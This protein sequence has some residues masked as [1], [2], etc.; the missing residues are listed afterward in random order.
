MQTAWSLPA[1][2][3][4]MAIVLSLSSLLFIFVLILLAKCYINIRNLICII[5]IHKKGHLPLLSNDYFE[6][7]AFVVHCDEDREWIHQTHV[8]N[9]ENKG[10]KPCICDRDYEIG[11]AIAENVSKCLEKIKDSYHKKVKWFHKRTICV[12]GRSTLSWKGFGPTDQI[13]SFKLF[14][15]LL[16]ESILQC[17]PCLSFKTGVGE[18]MFWREAEIALRKPIGHPPIALS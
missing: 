6:Y 9:I 11:E 2:K 5:R 13:F 15:N 17:V 3:S 16:T 12:D 1:L 18:G 7:D 14:W 4:T 10:F 8:D